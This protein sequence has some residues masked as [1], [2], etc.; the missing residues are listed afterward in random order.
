MGPPLPLRSAACSEPA[1]AERPSV[2]LSQCVRARIGP[3]GILVH[4][5]LKPINRQLTV[6]WGCVFLVMML[7]HI[8][9]GAIDT[10]RANTILTE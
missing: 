6:L 7:S 2:P 5:A 10:R 8:V 1:V 4:A 3:S 9:A